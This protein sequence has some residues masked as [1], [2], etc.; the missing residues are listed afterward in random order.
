MGLHYPS[1]SSAGRHLAGGIWSA[2]FPLN[3]I[4]V[5]T[6]MRILARATAEWP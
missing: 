6:L 1:D 2:L 5:P 4:A 3:Q